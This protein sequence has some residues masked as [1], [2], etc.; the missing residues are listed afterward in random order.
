MLLPMAL[1]AIC[2]DAGDTKPSVG[3]IQST[4]RRYELERSPRVAKVFEVSRQVHAMGQADNPIAAFLRNLIY[5]LTPP[6]VADKQFAWLFSYA[7][8]WE[9]A[10]A[11][12][13]AQ[14][15]AAATV[16]Q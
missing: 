4:L 5:R 11:V 1:R 15:A 2:E 7:P 12:P 8:A 9:P 13:L 16:R 10:A 3:A 14:K 6:E